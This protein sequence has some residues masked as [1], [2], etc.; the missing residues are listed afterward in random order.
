MIGLELWNVTTD[1]LVYQP[2]SNGLFYI[3][4]Y[5]VINWQKNTQKLIIIK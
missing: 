4:L 5:V 1:L 2:E 3:F